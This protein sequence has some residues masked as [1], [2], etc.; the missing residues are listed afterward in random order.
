MDDLMNGALVAMEGKYDRLIGGEQSDEVGFAHA[1]WMVLGREERHQVHDI[2]HAQL[3]LGDML[4]QPVH[5]RQR[6]QRRHVAG[7]CHDDI[8]LDAFRVAGPMPDRRPA[9]AMVNRLVERQILQVL[10]LVDHDEV[11]VI[12]TAQAVVRHRE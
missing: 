1:V 2:H 4:A 5:R 3:Q 8:R 11:D 10:L 9:C 6:L 12:A 7:A